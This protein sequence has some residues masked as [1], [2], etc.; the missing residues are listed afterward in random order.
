MKDCYYIPKVDNDKELEN[1]IQ[2][3]SNESPSMSFIEDIQ[4]IIAQKL[5]KENFQKANL[6]TL[7]I[8]NAEVESV[9]LI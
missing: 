1:K 5:T 6:D 7:A 3:I 8:K 2:Y 9:Q 4:E